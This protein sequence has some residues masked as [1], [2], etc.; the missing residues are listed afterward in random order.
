[1]TQCSFF[2]GHL[3]ASE[4]SSGLS[5]PNYEK[6]SNAFDIKYTKIKN[7]CE[8]LKLKEVFNNDEL[9][10]I[11]IFTDPYELH[12]PKVSAKGLNKNGKIIPGNLEDIK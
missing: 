4:S 2:K 7:N 5:L 8:L 10:I 9:E 6:I 11:E 3:V 12:E 1:L